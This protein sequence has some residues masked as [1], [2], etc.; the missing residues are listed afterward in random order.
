MKLQSSDIW[1]DYYTEIKNIEINQKL[2]ELDRLLSNESSE[3]IIHQFIAD[4]IYFLLNTPVLDHLLAI[5]KPRFGEKYVGD[6]ALYGSC[7][8]PWWTF[9]E[10]E[11][12]S[13]KLFTGK[14]DYS[15]K[16]F[17]A[18]RQVNDWKTWI[19]TNHDYFQ[20][21]FGADY[22]VAHPNYLIIIGRR[23]EIGKREWQLLNRLNDNTGGGLYISTFDFLLDNG[24][25]LLKL[26]E[27]ST[28]HSK[29]LTFDQFTTIKE[30]CENKSDWGLWGLNY[31]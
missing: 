18:I 19:M 20:K 25:K 15:Q 23:S 17:H 14:G 28:I 13:D 30:K 1:Y 21:S 11:K 16:L 29:A 27:N 3:E 26:S 7:N 5:S 8:G 22:G 12:P 10:I 6:F 24:K 31:D 9:I 2:S 4:N